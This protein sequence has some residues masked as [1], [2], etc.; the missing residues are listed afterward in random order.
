MSNPFQAICNEQMAF[1]R[2]YLELLNASPLSRLQQRAHLQS[3]SFTLQQAVLAYGSELAFALFRRTDAIVS[4]SQLIEL[5][6]KQ[7]VVSPDVSELSALYL[8]VGSWLHML[9]DFSGR[10]AELKLFAGD[11]VDALDASLIASSRA[12]TPELSVESLRCVYIALEELVQRQ[13]SHN[14]EC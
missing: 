13:R 10:S 9:A 6:A 12:V 2:Y 3:L 5:A 14:V 4:V 7:R 11:G 1:S 8:D